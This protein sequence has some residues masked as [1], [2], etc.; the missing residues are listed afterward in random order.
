MSEP[1]RVALLRSQDAQPQPVDRRLA[2]LLHNGWLTDASVKEATLMW[3]ADRATLADM[4]SPEVA[5][6]FY[7]TAAALADY[8]GVR[9]NAM[10]QRAVLESALEILPSARLRHNVKCFLSRAACVHADTRAAEGW[11][12]TCDPRSLDLE[13]DSNYRLGRALLDTSIHRYPSVLD[14]LGNTHESIP[15]HDSLDPLAVVLRAHAVERL[16]SEQQAVAALTTW[17]W[18]PHGLR[19]GTIASAIHEYAPLNLCVKSFPVADAAVQ[20]QA[21][22]LNAMNEE[23]DNVA[24]GILFGGPLVVIVVAAVLLFAVV[25]VV[26]LASG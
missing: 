6:R 1:D 24:L 14:N 7:Q 8:H 21:H 12:S 22:S 20:K 15:I 10:S 18:G 2:A 17:M 3:T 16:G 25:V 23:R 11:L 13:C 4:P 19:R 9:R 5:T 26:T